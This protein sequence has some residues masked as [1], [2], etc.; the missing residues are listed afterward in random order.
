MANI[1]DEGEDQPGALGLDIS[2]LGVLETPPS[3]SDSDPQ[4]MFGDSSWANP[5]K[6]VQSYVR[7]FIVKQKVFFVLL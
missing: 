3:L 7:D 2:S 6:I 4:V 5:T 1:G